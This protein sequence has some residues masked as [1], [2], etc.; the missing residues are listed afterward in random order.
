MSSNPYRL[1]SSRTP[2]ASSNASA[3]AEYAQPD[4]FCLATFGRFEDP[5]RRARMVERAA[6]HQQVLCRFN[7]G[8]G[9]AI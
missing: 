3:T 4:L 2:T 1:G 9:R 6:D 8:F 5:G 7:E